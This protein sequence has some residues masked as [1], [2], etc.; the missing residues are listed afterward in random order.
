M[1]WLA[2]FTSF[3]GCAVVDTAAIDAIHVITDK[4]ELGLRLQNHFS[5]SWGP[6]SCTTLVTHNNKKP[7]QPSNFILSYILIMLIMNLMD[8][9]Y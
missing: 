2:K 7:P 6:S 8:T 4:N 1:V 9:S 5:A 3:I